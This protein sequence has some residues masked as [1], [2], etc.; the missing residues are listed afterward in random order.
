MGISTSSPGND[1]YHPSRWARHY[2]C[3]SYDAAVMQAVWGDMNARH[4]GIL[5]PPLTAASHC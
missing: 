3:P 2:L 1:G 4:G 5:V